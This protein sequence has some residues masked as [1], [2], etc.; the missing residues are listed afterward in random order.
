MREATNNY[1]ALAFLE[2]MRDEIE[3]QLGSLRVGQGSKTITLPLDSVDITARAVG[4]VVEVTLT[5]V[6][7]NPYSE[8][9][10]AE[11]VFP[12]GGCSSVNGFKMHVGG[13]TVIG[14]IQ[15][16]RAAR[17]EYNRAL[18]DGKRA[19]LLEQERDDVFT[20]QVGN[21]PPQEKITVELTYTEK[22]EFF[23]NGTTELR[24]PL[25]VA[26]RFVPGTNLSREQ[27]GD[28]VI[29]D[30]DLVPDASRISPPRLA[31]GLVPDVSL[32][33]NVELTPEFASTRDGRNLRISDLCCSQHAIKTRTDDGIIR[34]SLAKAN[35]LLNRDFILRWRLVSEQMSSSVVLHRMAGKD[36]RQEGYAMLSLVPP[37]SAGV[38][39][40]PRDVIFVLDRS[41]SMGGAKMV[42]ASRACAIL[43]STL[44][45]KDRFA[46]NAFDTVCE[47]YTDDASQQQVSVG[48]FFDAN[49][50][51]VAK[52]IEFLR[53]VT[54]RGGTEL[55]FALTQSLDLVNTNN[56]R[57]GRVPVIVVLTDGQIGNES[58]LFSM[59]Q[60]TAGDTRI[61]TVGIDT[62]VNYPFLTRLAALGTGTATFVTPGSQLEDALV[63]V[64]REIGSPLVTDL[65]IESLTGGVT[66]DALAPSR[67][68]DL[69]AGRTS[70]CL[71]R[72][73]CKIDS[74]AIARF[75]IRG[76]L[77]NG[78]KFTEDV[79][80]Q[81]VNAESISRLWAREFIK[82]LEDEFRVN[83]GRQHTTKQ[84]IV[85]LSLKFSV[86]TKFTAFVAVDQAE[87]V[88]TSGEVRHIVQPV[89]MP[90]QWEMQNQSGW[91]GYAQQL[92]FGSAGGISANF[93]QTGPQQ[94]QDS[95]GTAA[96]GFGSQPL[97]GSAPQANGSLHGDFPDWDTMVTGSFTT[98][99]HIPQVP[100][101]L[102]QSDH[103][104]HGAPPAP[105]GHTAPP[106]AG[107]PNS[108]VP[109]NPASRGWNSFGSPSDGFREK[110]SDAQ[111]PPPPPPPPSMP[112]PSLNQMPPTSS[113]ADGNDGKQSI[114]SRSKSN[115]LP[116][117]G[118]AAKPFA[119]APHAV[120][121]E[122]QNA[123]ASL[124]LSAWSTM[125]K[126][127]SGAGADAK[128]MQSPEGAPV[129][130]IL[131]ALK[132]FR[133]A[134][135][136]SWTQIG[137]GGVPDADVI[138]NAR[139]SLIEA[140]ADHPVGFQV[141]RLQK[142]LRTSAIEYV[143]ALQT[144]D[145]TASTLYQARGRF[146]HGLV[147]AMVEAED[148]MVKVQGRQGAFWESIV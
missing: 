14:T 72:L 146:N 24:L 74:G 99:P 57:K 59:I 38:N 147:D 137:G 12:L 66:I 37:A 6:F 91:G 141:P 40:A 79:N 35:D 105:A 76:K 88:N 94:R 25:V 17:E 144:F 128:P 133:E 62:A 126:L 129:S 33:I 1:E 81:M 31:E 34:I 50:T 48:K 118:E 112:Q 39:A 20:M 42:S 90:D 106:S 26:P 46:I 89:H 29:S 131:N 10:E 69:F 54:A 122:Q 44:G 115:N 4:R 109:V 13:R 80:A 55:G 56:K 41:G 93:F 86:L 148:A 123:P 110:R 63:Q 60:R 58:Q 107:N 8:H 53:A 120:P 65:E 143:A 18:S 32:T 121:Q 36:A 85:D 49:L 19:S 75:R 28:G 113:P 27:V 103:S 145:V 136:A 104:S 23:E 21:I 43:M 84:Q 9:L 30:T 100:Q 61:F 132:S 140:L 67:L 7:K 96:P 3:R 125:K 92:S 45:P 22:L 102:G 116:T 11:Y 16:R 87:V 47:W 114:R 78:K 108:A 134:W 111:V 15:E 82:E 2:G 117:P 139:K 124:P 98:Y 95:G 52:G 97:F 51:N 101:L 73:N 71:F 127:F 83:P 135:M 138:E 119:P 130:R 70:D 5:Q 64:G 77:A 68:P 142:F